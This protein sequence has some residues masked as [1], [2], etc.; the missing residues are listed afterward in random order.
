MIEYDAAV[1]GRSRSFGI[2]SA[3]YDPELILIIEDS[4]NEALLLRRALQRNQFTGSIVHLLNGHEAMKYLHGAPPYG[5]RQLHP[6]P[7][8]IVTDL[9][10]PLMDGFEVL[11]AVRINVS[12]CVIPVIVLSNSDDQGDIYKAYQL[13]ANSYIAKPRALDDLIQTVGLVI[14]YWRACQKPVP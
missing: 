3:A 11:A 1:G 14:K 5:D 13:G 2:M 10:M 9:Q 4:E 12:C 7:G 8:L 6:L